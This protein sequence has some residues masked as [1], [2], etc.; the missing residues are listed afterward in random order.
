MLLKLFETILKDVSNHEKTKG[1]WSR[2]EKLVGARI[3]QVTADLVE[4][5]ETRTIKFVMTG[6]VRN[7]C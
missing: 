5:F 2:L 1:E 6:I 3:W 4:Q 7:T